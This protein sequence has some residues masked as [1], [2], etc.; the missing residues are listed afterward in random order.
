MFNDQV[1]ATTVVKDVH[2]A[3]F[4]LQRRQCGP[5]VGAGKLFTIWRDQKQ[6]NHSQLRLTGTM[7]ADRSLGKCIGLFRYGE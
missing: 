1:T 2:L 4:K 5:N 3:E 6:C 7:S